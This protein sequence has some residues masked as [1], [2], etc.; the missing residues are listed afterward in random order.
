MVGKLT[1]FLGIQFKQSNDGI[2]ISQ[3]KYARDLVKRFGMKIS[4]HART[5][6]SSTIKLSKNENEVDVDQTLYRS[7]IDS[8]LYL[9]A[10]RLDLAFR[11][12]V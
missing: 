11:V 10:R 12:G 4:K 1:Y 5:P 7:M 3:S 2:F 9:T 6:M 8:L